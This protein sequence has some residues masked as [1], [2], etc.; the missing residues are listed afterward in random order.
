MQ[1][2]KKVKVILIMMLISFMIFGFDSLVTVNASENI[3]KD[4]SVAS[5]N[6][7]SDMQNQVPEESFTG[8]EKQS[9]GSWIYIQNGVF[10]E[11]FS[12]LVKHT[13]G[14]YYY[15]KNGKVDFGKTGIVKHTNGNWHYVK[16]GIMQPKYSGLSKHTNK[17]YYYVK[18]GKVQFY[19][20]GLVKHT[21]KKYYY[22]EAGV[23]KSNYNGIAKLGTKY[24]KVKKGKKVGRGKSAGKLTKKELKLAATTT[25]RGIAACAKRYSPNK[26]KQVEYAS[27][28]VYKYCKKSKY[29]SKGSAYREAYGPFV[30]KQYTCAGSTRALGLVLDYLKVPWSHANENKWTHQ[31]CKIKIGGKKGWADGMIGL[32]GKGKHAFI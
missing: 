20:S 15:V 18:N 25:A 11:N 19:K 30:K 24:Y 10:K 9:D 31:W 22:I 7:K 4:Y 12:G 3:S 6:E 28:K 14:K 1:I 26:W 2:L 21:N 32:S 16:K 23:K 17:K 5:N 13:D 8:L 29:T 27:Q